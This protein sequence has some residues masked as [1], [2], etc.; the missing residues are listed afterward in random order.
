[1]TESTASRATSRRLENVLGRYDVGIVSVQCSDRHQISAMDA[2]ALQALVLK[3]LLAIQTLSGYAPP[4]APPEVLFLPPEEL[5]QRACNGR[6]AVFGWFPPGRII[7]LEDR[8]DPV[9]DLRARAVLLH[10][11]VHFLQQE[12]GAYEGPA[13]CRTWLAR[14]REAVDL[15][16]RWLKEQ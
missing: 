5:Q 4:E 16:W 11:L 9:G 2:A 10:E 3:L 13:T 8:L 12:N 15:E 14:E 1:R 6:C 7:Y